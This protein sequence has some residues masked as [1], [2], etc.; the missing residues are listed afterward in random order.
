MWNTGEFRK[1]GSHE[2]F[3]SLCG[4]GGDIILCD[5]CDKSFCHSCVDRISGTEQLQYL[6]DVET[7]EFQCY[8]CDSSP[9]RDEQELCQELISFFKK[10]KGGERSG[11]RSGKKFKSKKYI[12]GSD[13]DSSHDDEGGVGCGVVD[14][15]GENQK[16]VGSSHQ[17][18]SKSHDNSKFGKGSDERVES[19]KLRR[20]QRKVLGRFGDESSHS[21]DD[22]P[23][24]NSDDI[25]LSDSSITED[26][27]AVMKEKKGKKVL[28][29][30]TKIFQKSPSSD[31]DNS[32]GDKKKSE[33]DEKRK[34]RL[35]RRR[36]RK[37]GLFPCGSPT[38]EDS[39]DDDRTEVR[40]RRSKRKRSTTSESLS[41]VN[42]C[43]KQQNISS[44]KSRRFAVPLS[45]DSDREEK[46]DSRMLTVQLSDQDMGEDDMGEDDIVNRAAS[47]RTCD[48]APIKYR[49]PDIESSG[50]SSDFKSTLSRK[51]KKKSGDQIGI[52]S[53][54]DDE[55][56]SDPRQKSRSRQKKEITMADL[57]SD[58]DFVGRHNTLKGPR[59]RHRR[60]IPVSDSDTNSNKSGDEEQKSS[61]MKK[62]EDITPSQELTPRKRKKIRKVIGEAKLANETK[63]ALQEERERMERLKKRK[64][65]TLDEEDRLV[66]EQDP[67][68]KE[69][70]IEVRRSLVP[71][72]KPHQ[73]EGIK[74]LYDACVENLQRF[75]SGYGAGAIL[76]HCMGLGK[77]L[78][79]CVHACRQETH[80]GVPICFC[81][82]I[83]FADAL[84]N[85]EE[86]G[87]KRVLVLCPVN[88]VH[89]WKVEFFKWIPF[90]S[91]EYKVSDSILNNIL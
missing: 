41:D 19:R 57:S 31:E 33:G 44:K 70:K 10:S 16:G 88:T 42:K 60:V 29:K 40:K 48:S 25:E 89:N 91:C 67:E 43:E 8:L 65:V 77:T 72:I 14:G 21:D 11:L 81:Q 36:R 86:S 58:E 34:E 37:A 7:A 5:Y 46:D 24:V 53:S 64:N 52:L 30:R 20:Q 12:T 61:S 32:D 80:S 56:E 26:M 54:S 59:S 78:Q 71:N 39:S 6:K 22:S 35:R 85:C 62:D 87:M 23:Q 45:S 49:I 84:L 2:I 63:I 28:Q 3:C 9:L 75:A 79:V 4:D 90:L 83:A 13:M 17:E 82:V 69:I 1:I 55:S 18:G 51:V 50:S 74:F 73:W 15:E 47:T 68:S 76:A 66:L 38:D 27:E